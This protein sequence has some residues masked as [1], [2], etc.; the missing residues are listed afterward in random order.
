MMIRKI[1]EK[2]KLRNFILQ[3]LLIAYTADLSPEY[4]TE[5]VWDGTEWRLVRKTVSYKPRD[6]GT[7]GVLSVVACPP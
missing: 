7:H 5:E 4:E 3:L 1:P 6:E 2:F